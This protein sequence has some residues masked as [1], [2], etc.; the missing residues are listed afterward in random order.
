M[1][2]QQTVLR[3]ETNLQTETLIT[4]A[5]SMYV[6]NKSYIITGGTG[7]QTNPITGITT[8]DIVAS[9]SLKITGGTGILYYTF[10]IPASGGPS[11]QTQR[12]R[13]GITHASGFNSGIAGFD[14]YAIINPTG[15][16]NVL[17]NDTVIFQV[18]SYFNTGSTMSFFVIPDNVPPTPVVK[19]YDFLD[20]YGDIPIKINK[21]FAELQDISKRNSDYSIGLQLPGSK[22]NN[23][24]FESYFNVD[25]D[26]LYFDVTKRVPCDVLLNDQAYF[27]GYLRLNKVSVLNSKIEYDVTLYSSIGELYGK[28]GNNLLKDLNYNDIDYHYNHYFN[29]YSTIASW[30]LPN[31]LSPGSVPSLWFYPV[32]HNGYNYTADTQNRTIVNVSGSTTGSTRLYTSTVASGYTNYAAFVAAGGLEYRINSPKS[33]V[34]DNQLKPALNVWGLI[35]LMFKNYGYTIKSDFFNTPWFKLLYMYGYFNSDATKFSY[36]TPVPQTL[37][38]DGIEVLL[39]ESYFD[40]SEFPCGTQYYKTDRTYTI[41][42]VKAGTGIPALCTEDLTVGLDFRYYPCYGGSFDNTIQ[43]TIPANSTGT[44]YSWVSNQYVDCGSGCPYTLEYTQNFGYNSSAS[45]VGL[46]SQSLAFTPLPPNTTIE[47]SD[48][49]YV[50]FSLVMDTNIKQIDFLSSI[51]KKFNLVFIPD[52]DVPNQIIIEPYSYYIGTGDVYDWTNKI[53][54]DKG[55]SVEPALNYIESTLNITDLEDGDDG[56]KQFKDRQKLIYGQNIVYNPTDFKSQEK[57]IETIYSPEIIRKWDDRIGIPLG[58]NYAAANKPSNVGTGQQVSWEYTGLKSKPKLFFNLGN[59]SPFLDQVGESYPL[60]LGA[61]NTQFFRIQKSDGTNIDGDI[62]AYG[63]IANPVISHTMPMGNPDSNKIN[64]DSICNLFKSEE[65][66]DIGIGI[67]TFNAYTENDIYSL[68]Y[69]NRV[70]NL[71][72]KNT[73]FLSGYFDLKQSDIQN[74]KPQDVI[75]INEQY[76][77]WNKIDGYNLTNPELTKVEL[78]QTNVVPQTYPTRYFKYQYCS[79]D[80]TT[81][82]FRT[83]FNP[84]DNPDI[85][86]FGEIPTSIRKTYYQWSVLYDYFV[87]VLGGNVSGYTS[88][89]N[90][91]YTFLDGKITPYNIWEVT[92]EDYNTSGLSQRYDPLNYQFINSF[93]GQPESSEYNQNPLIWLFSNGTGATSSVLFNLAPNCVTF[94]SLCAANNIILSPAGTP[95][96]TPTPTPSATPA[97][98]PTPGAAMLGSLLMTFDEAI[99]DRGI[100][101]YTVSVN[102]SFRDVHF[103]EATNLYST[104]LNPGDVVQ[105]TI[106]KDAAL[107]SSIDVYRRD[108]TTDDQGNDMGIRDIYITGTTSIIGQT[109]VSV[110][111]TATTISQDYNFEYRVTARTTGIAPTPTPTAVPTNGTNGSVNHHISLYPNNK[112]L[113]F[114]NFTQLD[115]SF[116]TDG[117]AK[118]NTD[119]T[120]DT[121]V[122]SNSNIGLQTLGGGVLHTDETMTT[123][124]GTINLGGGNIAYNG[125]RRETDGTFNVSTN[126]TYAVTGLTNSRM[127]IYPASNNK[128]YI[129]GQGLYS[130]T[131]TPS[132]LV[133]INAGSTYTIDTGFNAYPLEDLVAYFP[134]YEQ[135]DGKILIGGVYSGQTG[136]PAGYSSIT[137]YNSNGSLDTSF[138]GNP[139]CRVFTADIKQHTNGNIYYV[140]Y[141]FGILDQYGTPIVGDVPFANRVDS[142]DIQ[143]DGKA[144]L[145]GITSYGPSFIPVPGICR[146]NT[147][148]TLD[149]TFNAGGSGFYIGGGPSVGAVYDVKVQ[150]DDKII[151]GGS[152][153]TYNGFTYNNIIRLNADG[154][155]DTSF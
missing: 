70:N 3:V 6:S 30:T 29:L 148:G 14:E 117:I 94:T 2:Q 54:W 98:T 88:S 96:P 105:I 4:G 135:T 1:S 136:I 119:G 7:T 38:I 76:F 133:R 102:G 107:D 113:I 138:S 110:D 49:T 109:V 129:S 111:F 81:Y 126:I 41:Y 42:V 142:I 103:T 93:N 22:N 67:P 95:L 5:T 155:I 32:L 89:V 24:F 127:I 106:I 128:F 17:D 124:L 10:N 37:P 100:D 118:F 69:A 31:L 122:D 152:F 72:N 134:V 46:S 56:N 140:G 11:F 25:S 18:S 149:T 73:R 65:P 60:A 99:R 77:V 92:E 59:Y 55:F 78:I 115:G 23:R 85:E 64:N 33:P 123:G 114:G 58:I 27:R 45:N 121:S 13:C 153:S 20:L 83:Y 87:G 154:S 40:S 79:G 146:V 48:G 131:T 112:I 120:L 150:P 104:N 144:I 147:N 108:Y 151:V 19:T 28:I 137:R 71:Y 61:I 36:K 84:L 145:G 39:V 53:S 51:A 125:T 75:K 26:S 8:S 141:S 15:Y 47:F 43:V 90:S 97:P 66:Q 16:F 35:Q 86:W 101:N 9:I 21:S 63:S 44:T 34:L 57:K 74:L 80:T 50:D 62:Y 52:P 143:S 12:L 116:N 82:K 68:F 139:I 132:N 130:G 91:S